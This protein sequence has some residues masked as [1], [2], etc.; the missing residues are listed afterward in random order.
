MPVE[1]LGLADRAR[2]AVEDRPAAGVR[3]AEPPLEH[4]QRGR[5]RHELAGV[6]EL[7]DLVAERRV[8]PDLL[9]EEVAGRDLGDAEPRGEQVGLGAL[10]GPR[11]PEQYDEHAVAAPGAYLMKPS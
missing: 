2:E 7:G 5:V 6:D 3:P 1:R 4:A 9:A 8:A 10:T 11:R